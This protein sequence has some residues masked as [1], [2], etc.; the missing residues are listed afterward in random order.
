LITCTTKSLSR[1]CPPG[2]TRRLGRTIRGRLKASLGTRKET[3]SIVGMHRTR[4]PSAGFEIG[5]PG[6][7]A[8]RPTHSFAAQDGAHALWIG[9]DPNPELTALHSAIASTLSAAI[10]YQPE[11]RPYRPHITLARPSSLAADAAV[12]FV[13][14]N[15]AFHFAP[16]RHRVCTLRE[17][18]AGDVPRYQIRAWYGRPQLAS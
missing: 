9:V 12:Q 18:L 13:T 1:E 6:K 16:F 2:L 3:S 4:S 8:A 10:D 11:D 14:K 5:N 7:L 15:A 17:Q